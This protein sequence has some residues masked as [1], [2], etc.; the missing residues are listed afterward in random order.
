MSTWR[1]F[2]NQ[3]TPIYAN[4]RH[5]TLHYRGVAR[6]IAALI[7]SPDA[8]VL[9]HGCG[10]ATDADRVA[11]ACG[12]LFLCDAAPLVRDRLNERFREVP[13]IQVVSPEGVGDLPDASLDLV[14]SN[15][16]VQYLS[17]AE[18]D[19][20]LRLWRAKLKPAGHL[21]LADVIPPD[22][23][24]LTDAAALMR[25]AWQGGF[26]VAAGVGLV[27]TA[28]S[29]YRTLRSRLGLSQYTESGMLGILE[30]AGFTAERR[31]RNMG[32]NPARMTFAA[33]PAPDRA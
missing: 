20:S 17:R 23:S 2:W 4:E 31:P 11:A 1:D 14:V 15:S 16:V 5:K 9:D 32:H 3:D 13:N 22:V 10:E 19:A 21:V 8:V 26:V 18:L 12:K 33:R 24:P 7:P 29:D 6:D 27:R 30:R 25:F 28:L